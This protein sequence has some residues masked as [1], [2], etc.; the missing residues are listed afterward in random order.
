[1]TEEK[2]RAKEALEEEQRKVRELQERLS[3]QRK[4]YRRWS[5]RGPQPRPRNEQGLAPG[6]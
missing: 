5:L 2:N 4:V 6:P 1:M 3:H